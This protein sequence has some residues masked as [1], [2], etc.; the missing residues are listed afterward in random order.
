MMGDFSLTATL[1]GQV[2]VMPGQD[3]F[4]WLLS[5]TFPDIMIATADF[6]VG[7]ALYQSHP[8]RE[9]IILPG[10]IVGGGGT[11]WRPPAKPGGPPDLSTLL[12]KYQ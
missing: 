2:K 5:T 11:G 3:F 10:S 1:A 9:V 6:F 12:N 7:L 8:G 4:G